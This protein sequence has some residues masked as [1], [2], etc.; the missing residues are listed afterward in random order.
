MSR[1]D[2]MNKPFLVIWIMLAGCLDLWSQTNATTGESTL[3]S[4]PQLQLRFS[5]PALSSAQSRQ[6][7]ATTAVEEVALVPL[8]VTRLESIS[9][10]TTNATGLNDE[11]NLEATATFSSISS[12]PAP[13]LGRLLTQRDPEAL[14]LLKHPVDA[15]FE[16]EVLRLGKAG[17]SCSIVTA[18]KRRNP[19]CLLNPEF[20]RFSW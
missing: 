14:S 11:L 6:A 15:I 2:F 5:L 9:P 18:I 20:L 12:Y 10:S 7:A 19:L 13:D 1:D 8:P 4:S 3:F 17:F 16:Q